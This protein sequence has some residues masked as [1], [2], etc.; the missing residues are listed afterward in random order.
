[1]KNCKGKYTIAIP[2]YILITNIYVK[3]KLEFCQDRNTKYFPTFKIHKTKASTI[4]I[5]D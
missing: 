3:Y 4:R 2:T 1:M 5:K